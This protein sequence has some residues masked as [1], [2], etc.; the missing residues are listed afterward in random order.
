MDDKKPESC[1]FVRLDLR[2]VGTNLA[3]R[4]RRKI[5]ERQTIDHLVKQWH[6]RW[7]GENAFI[8]FD[9]PESIFDKPEIL[10]SLRLA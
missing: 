3:V 6:M 9:D 8:Y 10:E 5:T 7:M 1:W 2:V 4:M